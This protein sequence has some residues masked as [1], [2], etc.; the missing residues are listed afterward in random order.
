M[1]KNLHR[2]NAMQSV[3]R[4]GIPLLSKV[5]CPN[6]WG[7]FAPEDSLW[8]S[9]HP[10]LNNDPRLPDVGVGKDSQLRFLP[11]RFSL[12]GGAIDLRGYKCHDLACPSCHLRIPRPLYEIPP[13]FMSILG[14]PASGKS[15]FLAAMTWRLRQTFPGSFFM[16]FSDA[17]PSSNAILNDYEAKQFLNLQRD[18]PVQLA[19]TEEVGDAYNTVLMDGQRIRFVKPFLF[20]LTPLSNHPHADKKG[21]SRVVCVYDNA[22]ESFLPGADQALAPV[23]RHLAISETLLFLFDPTQDMRFRQACVGATNDPQMIDRNQKSDRESGVRQDIILKNAA[24]LVRR[25]AG[26]SQTEK[27]KKPLVVI[28]TKYDSWKSLLDDENLEPPWKMLKDG[29]PAGVSLSRVEK[30]SDRLKKLLNKF[31]PELVA[32]AEEFCEDVIYIPV[33]AT[34]CSPELLV[35]ETGQEQLKIRPKNIDPIWADVPLIYSLSKWTKGMVPYLN[36]KK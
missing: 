4:T 12:D 8:I 5:T 30:I 36:K 31:A 9:A 17:D 34:G 29:H 16:S 7:K 3:D 20:S 2:K 6:C 33:S 28:V 27:H 19:K 11:T 32:T 18:E 26:I 24:N 14:A 22:G 15:Y 35:S 1:E 13:F 10:S 23:T 21:M 25:Y